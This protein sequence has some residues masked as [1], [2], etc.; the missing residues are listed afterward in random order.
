VAANE[1]SR[2]EEGGTKRTVYAAHVSLLLP[3]LRG[4]DQDVLPVRVHP[5]LG[6]LGR[7]IRHQGC[8]LANISI[9]HRHRRFAAVCKFGI[10]HPRSAPTSARMWRMGRLRHS[11]YGPGCTRA[12]SA[13]AHLM[14]AS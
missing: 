12:G 11:L 4:I 10:A 14:L 8:E 13:K 3:A 6:D 7:P 5:N 1:G 2:S 9:T